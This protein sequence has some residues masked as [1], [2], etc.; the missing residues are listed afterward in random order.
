MPAPVSRATKTVAED[1]GDS[2]ISKRFDELSSEVT[3]AGY[4]FSER[5]YLTMGEY[6]DI[7]YREGYIG[8]SKELYTIQAT[9]N[10]ED[11]RLSTS[12]ELVASDLL[13]PPGD[14]SLQHFS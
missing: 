2:A 3:F 1:P 14:R 7:R 11:L 4:R 12:I 5:D 13:E 8:N 10:F 9:K 6:L